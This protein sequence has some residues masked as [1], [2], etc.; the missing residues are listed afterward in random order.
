MP[1]GDV[2]AKV[3]RL[4]GGTRRRRA[5]WRGGD[6]LAEWGCP[7]RA[8]RV[9]NGAVAPT[10]HLGLSKVERHQGCGQRPDG[11]GPRS[12]SPALCS[13]KVARSFTSANGLSC[14]EAAGPVKLSSKILQRST[15]SERLPEAAVA[16]R[17]KQPN[18]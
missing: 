12:Q 3:E 14:A 15:E 6:D 8:T 5:R 13:V 1:I 7:L 10:H 4:P 11:G 2:G 18:I 9:G 17:S 16:K